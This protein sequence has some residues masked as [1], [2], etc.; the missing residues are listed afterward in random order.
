M[1]LIDNKLDNEYV[2]R[3]G[4]AMSFLGDSP[5]ARRLNPFALLLVLLAAS[6]AATAVL[7]CLR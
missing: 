6:F 7:A 4:F 3:V 1:A 5:H 2:R